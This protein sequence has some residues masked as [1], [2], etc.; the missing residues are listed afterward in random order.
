MGLVGWETRPGEPTHYPLAWQRDGAYVLVALAKAG[1]HEMVKKLA[2]DFAEKD[3]FGGFGSEAD[4]PGLSLWALTTAANSL[5]DPAFDRWLWPH[6]QRKA[7]FILKMQSTRTPLSENYSGPVVPLHKTKPDNKL[8]AMPAQN[9]LIQGRMD[10]HYPVMFVNA[11]SFMGLREAAALASRLGHSSP[12]Q[13]WSKGARQ[14]QGAWQVAMVTPAADNERTFISGMWPS[15]VAA[16][17]P[18]QFLTRLDQRWQKIRSH[19]DGFAERPKWTYFD[20]AEA[21]QWLLLTQ[22]ERAWQTLEWFWAN[23]SSPGMYTWWEDDGEENSSGRWEQVRGWVRPQ[24]VTPH[25]WT[26]AEMALLQMD[27]LAHADPARPNT[28]V[29]GAGIPQHW[30]KS[31]IKV[32]HLLVDDTVV[33]WEWDTRVL[34][35]TL[36]GTRK[37]VLP[38]EQ[39]AKSKIV[40]HYR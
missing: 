34:T 28:V 33:D 36:S 6:I 35:V 3:F 15:G 1:K 27:M 4:A 16:E 39:F 21:H 25:Y 5:N 30:L 40:T 9:G 11:V 12:Q 31:P 24:G 18:Q 2:K 32:K 14:L 17:S 23:Q 7:N 22:P 26:A 37:D 38:G 20:V 19:Q 13:D 8:V 29:I 10:H